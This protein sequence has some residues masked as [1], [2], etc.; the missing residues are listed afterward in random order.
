VPLAQLGGFTLGLQTKNS[1]AT[2]A[3]TVLL[4]TLRR[5]I[6]TGPTE[7]QLIA[8]KKNITG[9]FPLKIAS[10]RSIV[11]Y[12]AMIGF[13]GLPLDHLEKFTARVEAV[14]VE[15]IRDAF[16]RRIHPDRLA[17]VTVGG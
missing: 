10:N 11:S 9:G 15:Q 6:E 12:L 16:T 4:D 2:Q 7:A 13:Y 1:Q 8:A 3:Q 5:F 14:T 17:I